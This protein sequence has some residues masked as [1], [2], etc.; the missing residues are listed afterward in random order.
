MKPLKIGIATVAVAAA[1]TLGACG[2]GGGN[3]FPESCKGYLADKLEASMDPDAKDPTSGQGIEACNGVTYRS[4]TDEVLRQTEA[5]YGEKFA[6]KVRELVKSE[7]S[8]KVL[9]TKVGADPA[10][11][12]L[13]FDSGDTEPDAND[14]DLDGVPNEDDK[15]PGGMG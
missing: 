2:G 4:L 8:D 6:N 5:E 15:V 3:A 12:A 1:I 10:T 7:L 14:T 11:D 13:W 9:N